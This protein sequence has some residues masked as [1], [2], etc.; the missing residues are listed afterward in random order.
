MTTCSSHAF[1]HLPLREKA[2]HTGLKMSRCGFSKPNLFWTMTWSAS[3][4][5][6]HPKCRSIATPAL[7]PNNQL[8]ALISGQAPQAGC[9][10]TDSPIVRLGEF[11]FESCT[12]SFGVSLRSLSQAS[13]PQASFS[14]STLHDVS[15][16]DVQKSTFP[17]RFFLGHRHK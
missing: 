3:S 8:V 2:K 4:P 6:S 10:Q 17:D 11:S 7:K 12:A 9:C 5:R 1:V 13:A 16:A 14:Q 15:L